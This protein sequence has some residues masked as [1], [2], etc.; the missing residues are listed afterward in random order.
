MPDGDNNNSNLVDAHRSHPRRFQGSQII[1]PVL[2]RRS[3][4]ISVGVNL[5]P[6]KVCNFNCVYCQV[7]R[8]GTGITPGISLTRLEKELRDTLQQVTSGQLY[9]FAPFDQ[10]PP[11]LRR[12]NDI[13]LSGDGEPTATKE[14]PAA[15][16]V[17]ARLK[18]S[19]NLPDV[20]IVLITNASMLHKPEVQK[21]C[22]LL[23]KHQGEIWAKLD[24]GTPDGFKRV[25]DTAVPFQ[26]ILDNILQCAL[27][28]P[29]TIQTLFMRHDSRPVAI[30]EVTA[31][32]GRLT[33]II[34]AGGN[35]TAI[36]LHTIARPPRLSQVSS[37]THDELD[38]IAQIVKD[39]VPVPVQIYYGSS[40]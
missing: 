28:R 12:L 29:L 31:Y 11:S 23:D 7:D 8:S 15:C 32:T 14:F 1:Y 6:D 10:T 30:E 24:A 5:S 25:N 27:V 16:Q 36:Q 3:G 19:L 39:A 40:T 13:A 35:I 34:Q 37:L 38:K 26:R 18:Q 2:S 21:A 20:K 33:E 4:G 22:E 17:I 9:D